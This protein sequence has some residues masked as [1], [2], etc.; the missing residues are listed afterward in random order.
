[1][2][3]SPATCNPVRSNLRLNLGRRSE[4][5]Q[6]PSL[7]IASLQDPSLQ[8]PSLQDP[9]LQDPS[10]QDPSLQ[11]PSLQIAFRDTHQRMRDR[12]RSR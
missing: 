11:D 4:R 5:L 7:Q 3:G 9:S 12:L 8:D 10:L 6:G 2:S 1:M